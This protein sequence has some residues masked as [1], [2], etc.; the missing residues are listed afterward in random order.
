MFFFGSHIFL[1]RRPLSA[2]FAS[3]CNREWFMRQQAVIHL[4]ES[5][6]RNR[7]RVLR[8]VTGRQW[9]GSLSRSS[10][11]EASQMVLAESRG[12][13]S[14]SAM[15]R[16]IRFWNTVVAESRRKIPGRTGKFEAAV[17][18]G[19]K[20]GELRIGYGFEAPVYLGACHWLPVQ[21]WRKPDRPIA[22]F[23]TRS[24]RVLNAHRSFPGAR[25]TLARGLRSESFT[26]LGIPAQFPSADDGRT[27]WRPTAI[28]NSAQSSLCFLPRACLSIR[29]VD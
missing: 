21:R 23:V 28:T 1:L 26:D 15:W 20:M 14:L 2:R 18:S 6:Q 29:P 5:R 11:R 7:A 9:R 19:T 13:M 8:S 12:D 17:E 3:G 27:A 25:L 4:L 10:L 24:C 22:L 16:V